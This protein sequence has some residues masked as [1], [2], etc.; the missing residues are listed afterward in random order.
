MFAKRADS[1]ITAKNTTEEKSS[2][3]VIIYAFSTFAKKP[4]TEK[5]KFPTRSYNPENNPESPISPN[6]TQSQSKVR[7]NCAGYTH[8]TEHIT[9]NTEKP[10]KLKHVYITVKVNAPTDIK[11]SSKT[12]FIAGRFL[13]LTSHLEKKFTEQIIPSV[14]KTDSLKEVS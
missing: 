3:S 5:I 4:Q 8:K 13:N 14:D 10:L 6:G 11:I 7:H 9:E 1:I 2:K 12:G